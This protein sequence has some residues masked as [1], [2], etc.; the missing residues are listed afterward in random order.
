MFDLPFPWRLCAKE[1]WDSGALCPGPSIGR[2]PAF[3]GHRFPAFS[4]G[5]QPPAYPEK[6][7]QLDDLRQFRVTFGRVLAYVSGGPVPTLKLWDPLTDTILFE[8]PT[9]G[10]LFSPVAFRDEL[11]LFHSSGRIRVLG[12]RT[13]KVLQESSIPLED[14]ANVTFVRAFSDADRYYLNLQKAGDGRQRQRI[15]YYANDA[16]IPK[17]D[18]NG[19]LFAVD[20]KTGVANWLAWLPTQTVVHV[21]EYRLPFLV[22]F[23]R[24]RAIINGRTRSNPALEIQVLDSR[25]GETLGAKDDILNDRMLQMVYEREAGILEFSGMNTVI[26]LRFGPDG[27]EFLRETEPFGRR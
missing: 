11:L 22:L 26:R 18:L 6:A 4:G 13:G 9:G 21:P 10:L 19:D 24:T 2:H 8:A 12:G 14:A 25:T 5:A 15:R 7:G 27:T 23:S 20:R 16:V 17:L 3:S 1:K